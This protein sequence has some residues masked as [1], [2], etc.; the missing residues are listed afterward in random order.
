MPVVIGLVIAFL[1]KREQDF[2]GDVFID[3]TL[4]KVV[5]MPAKHGIGVIAKRNISVSLSN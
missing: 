1:I 3:H 5:H 4:W 2:E